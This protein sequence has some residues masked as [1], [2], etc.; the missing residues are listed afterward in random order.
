[1]RYADRSALL[2]FGWVFALLLVLSGCSEGLPTGP[3]SDTF[4]D[5]GSVAAADVQSAPAGYIRIG[6]VPSASVVSIGG[7]GSFVVLDGTEKL[8]EGTDEQVE[9]ALGSGADVRENYRLQVA[10][11][12]EP[13][14]LVQ[15]AEDAGYVTYT[16]PVPAAGCTRVFVGEFAPDASFTERSAFR[17]QAIED[18]VAGTDSFWKIVTLTE[19]VTEYVVRVE[20]ETVTAQGPVVVEA[21]SGYVLIDGKPY[22]GVGEVA[23]N[24]SGALAGINELPI[25]QY[26]YGVVPR[27]L[28]PTIYDQLEAQKAQ[29]VAARTYAVSGLGKR[30]ADGYDLLATTSD[31]VY[32]GVEAEHPVSTQA[33]DATAAIVA[34][35][36]GQLIQA[37][38]SS[39]SG[40]Y[41]ANNEEAFRSDPVPYLRGIPDAQRG[42]AFENVPTLEVFKRRGNPTNL[43][44]TKA[45]DFESDWSRYHRWAYEWTA[46]EMSEVISAYAGRDVGR[47]LEINAVERGPSGRVLEIE[48]VTENGTFTDTKDRIRSSLKY[49][50][51]SGRLSSL[52]ST[53]FYIEPMVDRKTDEVTGFKAY[54]GGWGHGVGLSQTGAVGMAEKG[55]GYDEILKHYYRDI[56]LE[57]VQY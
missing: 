49:V 11:T 8:L 56:D 3:G 25:E 41:T 21:S 54:G 47:V 18:G 26:L 44:N 35:Y 43:R 7:T 51:A 27:E 36:G 46:E 14:P 32:G 33:V 22:R 17:A 2:P 16:E 39:T 48:Y 29:A 42:R 45:G 50:D 40:G 28:P 1:M 20:G 15:R 55:A 5:E 24:S 57:A 10:C 52:R 38:F 6:V 53:L 4:V 23:L 13:A 19:G 34:T 30:S 31:Q 12:S 37:L 9:V